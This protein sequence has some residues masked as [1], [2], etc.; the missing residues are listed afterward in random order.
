PEKFSGYHT[1]VDLETTPAEQNIDVPIFAVCSGQLL[2]KEWASGYGGVAVQKC[3]INNQT[4]TV[5]YGHLKLA[6]IQ[7]KINQELAAGEQIG[8]LGQGYSTETDGER[9]H[10]HLGIHLG[11]TINILGYV[12][13][14]SELSQWLDPAKYL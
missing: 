4:V 7:T 2:L 3:E 13:K 14:E 12:Q 6:S 1:G 9:K 10:L 5:I 8:V 11:A